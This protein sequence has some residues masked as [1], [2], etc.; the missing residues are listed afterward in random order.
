MPPK[1]EELTTDYVSDENYDWKDFDL[2][3]DLIAALEANDIMKPSAIQAMVL[4]HALA[5]RNILAR[6]KNGTGKTLAFLVPIINQIDPKSKNLQAIILSPTRELALQITTEAKKLCKHIPGVNVVATI[7]GFRSPAYD[8][9]II[10]SHGVQLL[11][12]T[13]GR[14]FDLISRGLVTVNKV[15]MV[16]LDEADRLVAD[17]NIFIEQFD[18]ILR[19]IHKEHQIMLFS[20]TYPQQTKVF[21][22]RFMPNVIQIN[23]MS[24]LCLDGIKQY[25]A[26]VSAADNKLNGLYYLLSH[27]HIDQCIVFCNS[28]R[29]VEVLAKL[30]TEKGLSCGFTHSLQTQEDRNRIFHSFRE[31]QNPRNLISS[32]LFARGIDVPSVNVVINFDLPNTS[33]TYLHR[34]GRSGRFARKA[35]TISLVQPSELETICKFEQEL[36]IEIEKIPMPINDDSEIH[37]YC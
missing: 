28:I 33:T 8:S 13:P 1:Y 18:K 23:N 7:G 21:A 31:N 30:L 5:N 35:I 32:D 20:A 26:P 24:S 4:P 15:K 6:S 16:A 34:I 9:S 22:D 11:V 37:N 27:L 29:R 10:K 36:D 14:I 3:V 25:Y 2:G 19:N 12:A 17:K